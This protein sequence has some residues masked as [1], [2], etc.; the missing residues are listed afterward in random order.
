MNTNLYFLVSINTEGVAKLEITIKPFSTSFDS[1]AQLLPI[2]F[3][4]VSNFNNLQTTNPDLLP[5]LAW[6]DRPD[7]GF[8]LAIFDAKPVVSYYKKIITTNTI[9]QSD[10]TVSVSYTEEELTL[11]E[12]EAKNSKMR[13]SYVPVRDSYLKL[14][15]F[16]QLADAPI[17][18]QARLDFATF[19]QQL[20]AMFNIVDYSQLAWPP[21]P[22]S[23]PNII[24]PPFPTID[25][26]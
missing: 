10:K 14:T 5:N 12:V 19:R 3:L 8:W 22:T 1:G 23:A 24:I 4:T 13:T 17:T 20:R 21:I 9:N 18:E 15:D 16:T 7:L 11:P 6:L 26:N 25:F 2:N